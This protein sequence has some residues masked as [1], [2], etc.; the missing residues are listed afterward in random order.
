MWKNLLFQSS[1]HQTAS[2][3]KGTVC[4]QIRVGQTFLWHQVLKA[5]AEKVQKVKVLKLKLKKS[6]C[7]FSPLLLQLFV[8]DK[9]VT[10][11]APLLL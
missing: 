8:H 6:F 3:I 7:C 1:L 5:T 11:L 2:H 4:L 9:N 10:K